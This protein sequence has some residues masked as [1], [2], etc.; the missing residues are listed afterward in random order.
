TPLPCPGRL[1]PLPLLAVPRYRP[2]M[3]PAASC[4]DTRSAYFF[5]SFYG[6]ERLQESRA[7]NNTAPLSYCAFRRPPLYRSA[8]QCFDHSS[9]KS[10]KKTG[11]EPTADVAASLVLLRAVQFVLCPRRE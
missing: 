9:S 8:I 3:R 4:S 2:A 1:R 6:D 7:S 11:A 10:E 5:S